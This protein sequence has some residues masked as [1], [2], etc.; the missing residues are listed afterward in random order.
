MDSSKLMTETIAR[1][2]PDQSDSPGA[3][4]TP[5][6][7][8]FRAGTAWVE[9]MLYRF[10]GSQRS[11]EIVVIRLWPDPRAWRRTTGGDRWWGHRPPI[12]LHLAD[13]PLRRNATRSTWMERQA[14]LQVPP[15]F[16]SAV[17]TIRPWA[18]WAVLSMAAR[19]EGALELVQSAP[20]LAVGLAHSFVLRPGQGRPIRA[21]R[22]QVRRRRRQIAGWLGFPE[23]KASV[24]A[25]GRLHPNDR[26]PEWLLILRRLLNAGE[27]WLAHLNPITAEVLSLLLVRPDRRDRLTLGVLEEIVAIR[28]AAGRAL[29]CDAVHRALNRGFELRGGGPSPL[30]RS[31]AAADRFTDEGGRQKRQDRIE[32]LEA[33]GPFPAPPYPEAV[34][35]GPTPVLLRPLSDP[36]ALVEHARR[37][38]NCVD[39]DAYTRRI[40]DGTG[41]A[42]ELSWAAGS[43]TPLATLFLDGRGVLRHRW[44]IED[45]R[46]GCNWPAPRWL[47]EQMEDL[48]GRARPRRWPAPRV[49]PDLGLVGPV[50]AR[51][52]A[53]RMG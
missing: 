37:Q 50:G 20:A 42:Y 3:A 32:A 23:T 10:Q 38:R 16:R 12:D 53:G 46:L 25:I 44:A 36:L 26:T 31:V 11:H 5:S 49:V 7:R 18:Q 8:S 19:V 35:D 1:P 13:R 30:L 40:L 9:P 6:D 27:P 15:E 22:V 45:L 14:A 48:I 21:A 51:P 2:A 33:A 41:Y 17:G 43:Q 4:A 52:I 29:A 39:S 34:L 28:S 24:K 47:F